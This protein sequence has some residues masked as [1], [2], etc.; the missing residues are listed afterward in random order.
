MLAATQRTAGVSVPVHVQ[1]AP[2]FFEEA[3]IDDLGD[4][5]W[6]GDFRLLP[7]QIDH[8]LHP[9]RLGC[10][11]AGHSAAELP[12][13]LAGEFPVRELPL[14]HDDV[15]HLF[16]V[17]GIHTK[18]QPS[19]RSFDHAMDFVR[20]LL[21][22]FDRGAEAVLGKIDDVSYEKNLVVAS[23]HGDNVFR[24]S[25]KRDRKST[26]LNSSHITTSYAVFCLKKKT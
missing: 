15:D 22:F 25:E 12:K 20:A 6:L 4:S 3:V 19:Q 11:V 16:A 8:Q 18:H 9:F 14:L 17:M 21:N 13:H 2:G 10:H 1:L 26:R 5:E 24:H 7:Q 23:I